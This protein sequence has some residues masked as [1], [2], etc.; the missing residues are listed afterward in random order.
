[1]NEMPKY[2]VQSLTIEQLTNLIAQGDNSKDSQLRI[3]QDGTIF[4]SYVVGMEQLDGIAGRFETFG[5]NNNYVGAKAAENERYIK[6][7]FLTVKD[8]IEHPKTFVD[9]W[10]HI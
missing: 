6:S 5:A 1:M 7:L 2:A 9:T 3:K 8:W 4:L 10:V